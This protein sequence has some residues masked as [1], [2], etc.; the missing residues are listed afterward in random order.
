MG[1]QPGFGSGRYPSPKMPGRSIP[2]WDP[3]SPRFHD[4]P[5]IAPGFAR[6]K[7]R[8]LPPVSPLATRQRR[9]VESLAPVIYHL[10]MPGERLASRP[11]TRTNRDVHEAPGP[12]LEPHQ[13]TGS[14][15]VTCTSPEKSDGTTQGILPI[16]TDRCQWCFVQYSSLPMWRHEGSTLSGREFVTISPGMNVPGPGSERIGT[17]SLSPGGSPGSASTICRRSK[18]AR[19][20]SEAK[21]GVKSRRNQEI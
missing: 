8:P 17:E 6:P 15:V 9:P 5:R 2:E 4:C 13:A 1:G 12:S 14:G 20:E 7:S 16:C 21:P 19:A 3:R 10:E 11:G 18:A